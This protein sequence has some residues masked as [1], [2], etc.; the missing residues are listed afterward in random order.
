MN[1]I[2][3]NARFFLGN[4]I[5]N[6]KILFPI[7]YHRKQFADRIIAPEMDICIEGFQRSGNSFFVSIFKRFNHH[8]KVAHHLHSSVQLIKAIEYNI[9]AVLL[10]REP[11]DSLASLITWDEKLSI[12]V[13]ISTYID[14]YASI[15]P[16]VDKCYLVNFKALIKSPD[17]IIS[18]INEKFNTDFN[19]TNLDQAHLTSL[20]NETNKLFVQTNSPFPNAL[21]SERNKVNKARVMEHRSFNK[22]KKAYE[23]ILNSSS[24]TK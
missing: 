20:M 18:G 21:K 2:E 1:K 15:L 6:N 23:N 8:I 19:L 22:A 24:L 5:G 4:Y 10:I 16:F 11:Q 7:N 12:G 14:F 3:K 9:P 13:A 17:D